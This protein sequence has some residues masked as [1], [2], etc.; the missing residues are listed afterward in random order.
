MLK[1]MQYPPSS[2]TLPPHHADLPCPLL[3]TWQVI[4]YLRAIDF[5]TVGDMDFFFGLK[6]VRLWDWDPDPR[7]LALPIAN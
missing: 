5:K 6:D 1:V 7:P 2:L 4:Q 3:M